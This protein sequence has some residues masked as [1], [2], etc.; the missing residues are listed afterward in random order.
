MDSQSVVALPGSEI[1]RKQYQKCPNCGG[2]LF[3]DNDF[4]KGRFHYFW[5][6]SVGCSRTYSKSF[7]EDYNTRLEFEKYNNKEKQ[8]QAAK[9]APVVAPVVAREL[10]LV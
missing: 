2:R 5:D 1:Q 6:C 10:I 4:Y 7:I 3:L 9:E 8:H